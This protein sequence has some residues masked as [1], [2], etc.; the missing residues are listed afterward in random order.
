M[1]IRLAKKEEV[2]QIEKMIFRAAKFLESKGIAQWERFAI[3]SN[4][5]ICK[6]DFKKKKL[7]ILIDDSRQIVAAMS[8]G[9][10][11]EIDY[12]LWENCN[13][14]YFIHRLVVNL[15]EM[16]NQYGKNL[17]N[18]AKEISKKNNKILRLNAVENNS[19]LD[20][21]YKEQG[22]KYVSKSLGYNLF[23]L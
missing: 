22:F 3:N 21:Y 11:E 5:N 19:Y 2:F 18:Y 4:I 15:D 7:Y 10:A 20:S 1:E 12:K 9:E 8:F 6:K 16:G 23:E 13:N 17:I 14:N